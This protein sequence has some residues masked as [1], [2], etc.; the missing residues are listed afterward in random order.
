MGLFDPTYGELLTAKEVC[1][2]TG[3]TMNQLRNWRLPSRLDKAPFGFVSV[4]VS[5]Y[6]RKASVQLWL[7]KN[8]GSNVRYTPAGTDLDV[9]VSVAFEGDLD[10]LNALKRVAVVTPENVKSWQ[11][12]LFGVDAQLTMRYSNIVKNEFLSELLGREVGLSNSI[13]A[14]QRFSEPVWFEAV[15]PAIRLQLNE[16]YGLGLSR[17]EVLSVPVGQVPPLKEIKK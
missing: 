15:V 11:D 12:Y 6:Y 1:E 17:D 13:P 7:D 9:P 5:P 4:G 8:A 14:E 10:K 3:F 2:A 16:M